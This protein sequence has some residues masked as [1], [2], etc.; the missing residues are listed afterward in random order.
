MDSKSVFQNPSAVERSL[1]L[2][3]TISFRVVGIPDH[4][5]YSRLLG[6]IE[7][8]VQTAQIKRQ[9]Q[10]TSR[11]GR[12]VS[13]QFD[14]FCTEMREVEGIYRAV[15]KLPDTKFVL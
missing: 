15:G 1:E 7:S 5:Y 3:N 2:P 9:V 13:Y 11:T 6:A 10:R 14:I 12:Y 4:R 8:V